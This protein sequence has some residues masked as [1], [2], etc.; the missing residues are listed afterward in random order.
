MTKDTRLPP[1]TLATVDG[2]PVIVLRHGRD[3]DGIYTD[4]WFEKQQLNERV[5]R[6][7]PKRR[8]ETT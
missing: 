5:H 6:S 7:L 8:T 2:E 1:G 4:V 3:K